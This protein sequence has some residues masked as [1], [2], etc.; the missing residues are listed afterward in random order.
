[1]PLMAIKCDQ[2]EAKLQ[3]RLSIELCYVTSPRR[4]CHEGS[5]TAKHKDLITMTK[6]DKEVMVPGAWGEN[7]RVMLHSGADT[8]TYPKGPSTNLVGT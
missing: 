8:E 2:H 6:K 1:M 7:A 5:M 3:T 4:L